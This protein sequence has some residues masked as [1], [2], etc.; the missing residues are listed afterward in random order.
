M[1]DP[2]EAKYN[3]KNLEVLCP[4]MEKMEYF[5]F[6]G[7]LLGYCRQNNIIDGDDD[8]DFY[9][10]I[11]HRAEIIEILKKL[12][13]EISIGNP[14]FLQGK[15]IIE[16][17]PTYVD[18]YLY[19]NEEQREYVLERWNF[20]AQ[21]YNVA[22]HLH[23][24][25]EMIFPTQNGTIGNI[26]IK[27]PQ[28]MHAC[29]SFLYGEYYKIPMKKG[30]QYTTQI[31]ENKPL[32]VMQESPVV[33]IFIITRDRLDSLRESIDSYHRDIKTPFEIVIHDNDS[34]YG[35]TIDFLKN[36]EKEGTKVYWNKENDLRSVNASISDWM[37]RHKNVKYFVITDPDVALDS[38]AG[39]ILEFYKA[40]LKANRHAQVVGPMLE[41]DD[42]PDHYPF[43]REVVKSH[44]YQFWQHTPTTLGYDGKVCNVQRAAIDSTF[45]MYRRGYTWN[46][47][48]VGIRTYAPYSARHLDWYLDPDNL[49]EDQEYYK[50]G[51][52]S[53][54][55][56]W[57]SNMLKNNAHPDFHPHYHTVDETAALA[58][59]LEI[60][61]KINKDE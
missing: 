59:V 22:T 4:H 6:F 30:T 58:D 43:K 28:D 34:T 24:P 26:K 15:R 56:G 42:L 51:V 33:P 2:V 5:I 23:V 54:I 37:E 13:F 40:L 50:N 25:K 46:G 35:P 57:G 17:C 1:I 11:S 39:N 47:P 29:C 8:V 52:S 21:P 38:V 18:F 48:V 53:G 3:L 49:S 19:E 10:D 44:Y 16:G 27:V 12:E 41:I 55:G 7:T 36:L 45:G 60:K 31:F 9:V 32:V 14:Y 20:L 61:R